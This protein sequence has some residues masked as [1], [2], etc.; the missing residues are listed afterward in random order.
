M[1][2]TG[3]VSKLSRAFTLIELL[4]VIAIIAILAAMLL[5]A[6]S[7]AKMKA[8]QTACLSNQKQLGL[9]LV[10]Y[11]GD[12]EDKVVPYTFA[13]GAYYGGGFW[14][15]GGDP[16]AGMA[17]MTPAQAEVF[18]QGLLKNSNPLYQY[19]PNV[20]IMHCP[21]DV[22]Y[23]KLTLAAGWSYDS[24]SK[25][26]NI[27]GPAYPATSWASPSYSKLGEM[28]YSSKTFAFME[29]ADYRNYN[30]GCWN[31]NVSMA[32]GSP[33]IVWAGTDPVAMY[34]G[35]ISTCTFADGHAESH[36]WLDRVTVAAGNNAANAIAAS[37]V[38]L[39]P[40][41]PDAV[42]ISDNFRF[43]GWK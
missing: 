31:V 1:K 7:R 28:L 6:L 8:Y 16:A 22:R 39:S 38:G 40:T 21:G 10:M 32:G 11:A 26:G 17:G 15:N 24:Y 43:P 13:G 37:L 20:A 25:S 35:N 5:P 19:A 29:D 33:T 18:I 30:V 41:S 27:G 36:K 12:N 4:V 23:K 2:T 3:R 42:F 34:H 9:A 14:G